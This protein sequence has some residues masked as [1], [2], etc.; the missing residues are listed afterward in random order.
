LCRPPHHFCRN[1]ERPSA[2]S[3]HDR[4][5]QEDQSTPYNPRGSW[6]TLFS[7][8]FC[9]SSLIGTCQ[10]MAVAQKIGAKY[11]L[12]CSAKTGEG[13]REVFLF[14]TRAALRPRHKPIKPPS[15]TM[16]ALKQ[17]FKPGSK[18]WMQPEMQQFAPLTISSVAAKAELENFV[19]NSSAPKSLQTFRLLI[20]GKT[21][22][23][24]TTILTKVIS[25]IYI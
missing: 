20:V 4:G 11:Y 10:G 25:I 5:S 19:A 24:K 3:S 6:F 21:G 7:S 17:I 14:A 22:C 18:S 9:L 1:E 23:G 8:C 13:V 15:K 12:E 2:R 16:M